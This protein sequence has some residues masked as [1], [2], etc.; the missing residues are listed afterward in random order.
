MGYNRSYVGKA[1]MKTRGRKRKDDRLMFNDILWDD[2]L[3]LLSINT[4][5]EVII[6]D[7]SFIK[8]HQHGFGSK[9]D[10]FK[11]DIGQS[12]GGR[13]PRFTP[14]LMLWAICYAFC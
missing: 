1:R 12:K 6:I 7:T 3:K 10:L 11:Q 5:P 4:D 13:Q 2:I 14:L 8:L 9:R